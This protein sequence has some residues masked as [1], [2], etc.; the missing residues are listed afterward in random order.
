MKKFSY[1]KQI[2]FAVDP[3]I[4][5]TFP[6][7]PPPASYNIS[8]LA[9]LTDIL[10]AYEKVLIRSDLWTLNFL[11]ANFTVEELEPLFKKDRLQFF[12]AMGKYS[13]AVPALEIDKGGPTREYFQI[14]QKGLAFPSSKF[15]RVLSEPTKIVQQ[16]ETHSLSYQVMDPIVANKYEEEMIM[17]LADEFHSLPT[18]RGGERHH[19]VGFRSGIGHI[20]D[21]WSTGTYALY[22]DPEMLNYLTYCDPKKSRL[23]AEIEKVGN[24]VDELHS[25]HHLPSVKDLLLSDRMSK[26]EAFRLLVSDEAAYL[27]EWLEKNLVPGV[28]V[29]DAY[30]DNLKELPSKKNWTNWLKFG[31]VQVISVGLSTVLTA[32]PL[33]GALF[34]IGMSALDTASGSK[35]MEWLMDPYHPKEWVSFIEKKVE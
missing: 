17:S 25:M 6:S 28:D 12:A 18:P 1:P 22:L 7:I 16:I 31:A 30:L 21:I 32:N 2:G 3:L 20:L 4:P 8:L 29:R 26:E 10:L 19:D 35:I 23:F 24:P 5:I 9:Y 34:G 13:H 15:R 14:I 33:L 27:R 11:Y